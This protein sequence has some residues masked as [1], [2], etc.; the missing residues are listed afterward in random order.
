M[1][2]SWHTW[3]WLEFKTSLKPYNQLCL[4]SGDDVEVIID[5]WFTVQKS[6]WLWCT[7]TDR[8]EE[9]AIL[10]LLIFTDKMSKKP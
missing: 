2:D 10:C 1:H 8:M 4:V 7:G 3:S 9:G 5:N 6:V